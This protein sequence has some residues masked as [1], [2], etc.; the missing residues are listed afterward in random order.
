MYSVR[1]LDEGPRQRGTR[2]F[3]TVSHWNKLLKGALVRFVLSTGA[4]GPDALARFDH[5]EGYVLDPTLTEES[6]GVTV[7][8]MVRPRR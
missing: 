5:P 4:D 3:T 2:S 7:L 1:F 6:K 8:A